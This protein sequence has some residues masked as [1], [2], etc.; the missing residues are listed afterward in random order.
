MTADA[1]IFR[2]ALWHTTFAMSSDESRVELN[3][4]YFQMSGTQCVI[5]ATDSYRL[6]EK[7]F[8]I[9]N[10]KG[11]A[12]NVI[13]P[14]RTL[15]EV[16]RILET[17]EAEEITVRIN[18]NQILFILGETEVVS[19]II[20]GSYPDYKQI[21]PT[22]FKNEVS[23]SVAEMGHAIKTTSFFCK[24]GINDVRIALDKRF[25]DI[26]VRAENSTAGKN[27]SNVPS[28]SDNQ[29]MDIVFNY[30]FLLDGLSH[31]TD[32]AAQLKTNEAVSPAL[33]TSKKDAHFL[34]VIMPIRQ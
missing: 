15:A 13:V 33:L 25:K 5:A 31:L 1:Q 32:D 12:R 28:L 6:A 30:K 17:S 9:T 23:F 29:E 27:T 2:E 4:A 24:Q 7:T 26:T 14:A 34:Y 3:G 19:R 21:V 8:P 10:K 22:T 16:Q 11:S 18:E 20:V